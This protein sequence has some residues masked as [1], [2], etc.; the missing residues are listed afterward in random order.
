M[1]TQPSAKRG[2]SLLVTRQSIP[3][4]T[5]LLPGDKVN[6]RLTAKKR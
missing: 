6:L 2:Y 3:A 1:V 4:G 5:R